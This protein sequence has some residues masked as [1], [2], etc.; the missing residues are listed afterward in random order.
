[1]SSWAFGSAFRKPF[2]HI[3]H[4][5]ARNA[6]AR[7]PSTTPGQIARSVRGWTSADRTQSNTTPSLAN[8]GFRIDPPVSVPTEPNKVP[9]L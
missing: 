4:I 7:I 3:C 9:P 1:M 2:S 6:A 8:A 5:E